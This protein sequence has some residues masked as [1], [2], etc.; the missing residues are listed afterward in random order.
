MF[1]T[2]QVQRD[3][4]SVINTDRHF[5]QALLYLYCKFTEEVKALH[6]A[7]QNGFVFAD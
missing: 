5:N 4:Q 6:N 2:T 1:T 7:N 3:G